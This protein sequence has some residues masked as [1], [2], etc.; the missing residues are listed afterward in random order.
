MLINTLDKHYTNDTKE[1]TW[2]RV[3]AGSLQYYPPFKEHLLAFLQAVVEA[4]LHRQ[5]VV[6][7]G[8]G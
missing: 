7:T 8:Q 1:K 5:A 4:L 6:E 3:G 2:G